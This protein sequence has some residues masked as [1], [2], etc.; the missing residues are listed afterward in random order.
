[1]QQVRARL[2]GLIVTLLAITAITLFPGGAALDIGLDSEELRWLS[3][4]YPKHIFDYC[5]DLHPFEPG[6]RRCLTRQRRIRK[7][8]LIDAIDQLGTYAD[9]LA[10]YT[11]C[12]EYYPFGGVP[13]IGECVATRLILH[14]RLDFEIVEQL[15][16]EKC[17]E[18]WGKHG[19]L[20]IR[21]CA[22]NSANSYRHEGRL[23][24]W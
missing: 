7:Q 17:E 16:Y 18:K 23:P 3:K 19:A 22:V 14:H 2:A 5:L 8:V 4:R 12:K 9:A 6:L 10:L 1:M 24:E 21:N 20:A 15:I 11:E 13:P